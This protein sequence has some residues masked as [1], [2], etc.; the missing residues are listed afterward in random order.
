MGASPVTRGA[1]RDVTEDTVS[2]VSTVSAFSTEFTSYLPSSE[3]ALVASLLV[4]AIVS[5]ISLRR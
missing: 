1:Y 2:T 4:F 3:V 5:A